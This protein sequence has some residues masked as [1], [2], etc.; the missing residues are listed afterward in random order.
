MFCQAELFYSLTCFLTL[1]HFSGM[2][3]WT[4]FVRNGVAKRGTRIVAL[5]IWQQAIDSSAS[6]ML[7][8]IHIIIWRL[9][10]KRWHWRK[11][12]KF[13]SSSKRSKGASCHFELVFTCSLRGPN[14]FAVLGSL[15]RCLL[16]PLWTNAAPC[17]RKTRPIVLRKG[18]VRDLSKSSKDGPFLGNLAKSKQ[19]VCVCS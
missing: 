11:S 2:M 19:S 15:L 1:L 5:R 9:L 16:R 13:T 12:A 3:S 8:L 17:R 6:R 7:L 10:T 14:H 4:R 18:W